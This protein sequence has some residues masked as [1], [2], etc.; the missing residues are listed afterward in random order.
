VAEVLGKAGGELRGGVNSPDG[1]VAKVK[2]AFG[3]SRDEAATAVEQ[4]LGE[5]IQYVDSAVR[6]GMNGGRVY[7]LKGVKSEV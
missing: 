3:V 1:L 6:G 2:R 4:A 7:I 5:S